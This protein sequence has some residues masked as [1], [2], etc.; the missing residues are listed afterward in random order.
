MAQ[1]DPEAETVI[2]GTVLTVDDA[3][4][5]A[6]ALAVSDGRIIAVGTR[7]GVEGLIGPGTQTI[8]VGDGCVHRYVD[9]VA[10]R[11]PVTK[12]SQGQPEHSPRQR[13]RESGQLSCLE[14]VARRL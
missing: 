6:E 10:G 4:P 2:T 14:E 12:F 1:A 9:V 8:E 11:S 5:T 13:T 7:S 3:R